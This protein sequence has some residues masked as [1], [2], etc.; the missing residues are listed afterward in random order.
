MRRN[1]PKW[2]RPEQI[3]A[4]N[5]IMEVSAETG[6]DP[7]TIG[8][9]VA[10]AMRFLRDALRYDREGD[11]DA[12][13]LGIMQAGDDPSFWAKKLKAPRRNPRRRTSRRR[14]SRR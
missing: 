5:V 8:R 4:A 3:E 12:L 9:P 6:V 7:K 1:A 13:V 10:A 14:T 11:P 2:A